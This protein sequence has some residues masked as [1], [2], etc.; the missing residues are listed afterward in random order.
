MTSKVSTAGGM[1][2]GEVRVVRLKI[3]KFRAIGSADIELGTVA[4]LVG[5][6]GSGK[7]SVLRALNAFFNFD[8]EKAEFRTGS[9]AY[10]KGT[11][12]VIDV[13]LEG[14]A[15]HPALPRVQV[16]G[17]QVRAQL[18]YRRQPVWS[19]FVE[20]QWRPAPVG[21]HEALRDQVAYV[22][23][24][25]R[26]DHEVAHE[27]STGL[28]ERAVDEWVTSNR[29]RDRI[30][31]QVARLGSQL[32]KNS[33]SGFERQLRKV[34]PSDGPFFFE[35][36]Y[37]VQ[38]DYQLLLTNLRL[39]VREGGQLIPLSDS[40]SGTQSM[41]IL[42][43]YAYLAELQSRT[44]ILGVEEPE[45]N[46]HPQAQRQLVK[47]ISNLGLQVLLT[48]HSSTVVDSLGH[49]DVLLCR[50]IPGKTRGLEVQIRQITS[51]FF[52]RHGLD[53]DAYYKFH[54]RRNSEFIFADFVTVTESPIDSTVVLALLESAGFDPADMGMSL[55]ALDGVEQIPHMFH[56]LRELGIACAFVVD[57][58]YFL[59]YKNGDRSSSLDS[60]G[61]PQ[62]KREAKSSSLLTTLF[63]K[64]SDQ[65]NLVGHLAE[66]HYKAMAMLRSVGFFCFRYAIEV[67][68]VAA[69]EARAQFFEHLGVPE[70]DRVEA[71]LLKQRAK[72]IKKQEVLLPVLAA[73]S[74][75]NLPY[76]FRSIRNELPRMARDARVTRTQ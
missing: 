7:S 30:S 37:D 63:P 47:R 36:S 58:D 38:P 46:L 48:T 76:S 9:H 52:A 24:P 56:I 61:Y 23:I 22:V 67:D 35:L 14:L 44:F 73:L 59:P 28:L 13:T 55:V 39:G 20:G 65:E 2:L 15:E 12:S 75:T 4:A 54:R 41:A 50:R 27:S 5:Q 68:L 34:A 53:R 62:Y 19:V 45:Q 21:F 51:D 25:T 74:P 6:N 1:K 60:R 69:R 29:Q 3:E 11:Q 71:Q 18:K 17:D 66:N 43:L 42:A 16:G 33:L 26:R 72:V 8:E 10:A 57:K 31:P 70:A 64:V 40:G 32:R 49:E